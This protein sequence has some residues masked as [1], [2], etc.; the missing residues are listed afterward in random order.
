MPTGVAREMCLTGRTYDAAEAHSIGLANAVHE[1]DALMGA[2]RE[3]AASIAALPEP[4]SASTKRQFLTH[5][6]RLFEP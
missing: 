5:Q 6:P 2:A 1:P 4:L 3:L